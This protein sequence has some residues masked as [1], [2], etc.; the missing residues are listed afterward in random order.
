MELNQNIIKDLIMEEILN[1]QTL[2][3]ERGPSEKERVEQLNALELEKALARRASPGTTRAIAQG[4]TAGATSGGEATSDPLINLMRAV[5]QFEQEWAQIYTT[6]Q[7]LMKMNT[8]PTIKFH[9]S[10]VRE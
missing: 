2:F 4:M 3:Q 1:I 7:Q 8:D 10:G 5:G 6:Q 9:K